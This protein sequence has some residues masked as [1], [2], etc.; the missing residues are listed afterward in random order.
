MHIKNKITKNKTLQ[1]FLLAS[2]LCIIACLY[3][4]LTQTWNRDKNSKRKKKR[5][6]KTVRNSTIIAA[7]TRLQIEK[8]KRARARRLA[9]Y[10]L[11]KQRHKNIQKNRLTYKN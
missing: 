9:T 3:K 8:K 5:A 7:Q 11:V 1:L 10:S 4:P 6:K 2:Q